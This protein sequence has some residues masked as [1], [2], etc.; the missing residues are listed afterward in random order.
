MLKLNKDKPKVINI[1]LEK[2]AVDLK[3]QGIDVV[4]LLWKPPLPVENSYH[5]KINSLP[6]NIIA[7]ANK[8]ALEI[9]NSGKAVLTGMDVALKVIPG[10]HKDLILHSGP[11]I[12]WDRMCGPMR[13]AIIGALIY[14]DRAKKCRRSRK[15]C[16]FGKN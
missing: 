6:E 14:E 15:T 5:H 4:N 9:I 13:G 1:G 11:P 2:F 16:R 3:T 10:M 12:S 8:K 7:P